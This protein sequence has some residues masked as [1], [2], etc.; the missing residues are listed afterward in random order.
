MFTPALSTS[1]SST[2]TRSNLLITSHG[3]SIRQLT[4]GL[5]VDRAGRYNLDLSQEGRVE[6]LQRRV[7]NCSIT[8]IEMKP[9]DPGGW[10]GRMVGY[11]EDTHISGG[12][13]VVRENVDIEPGTPAEKL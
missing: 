1:L 4:Q 6:G 12:A 11:A 13:G 8:T 7:M 2:P 10:T 5:F 9:T 3:G